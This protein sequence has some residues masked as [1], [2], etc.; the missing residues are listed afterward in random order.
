[1]KRPKRRDWQIEKY[2]II[3]YDK[4]NNKTISGVMDLKKLLLSIVLLIFLTPINAFAAINPDIFDYGYFGVT[5]EKTKSSILLAEFPYNRHQWETIEIDS[6][7]R[8]ILRLYDGKGKVV[9]Q[10]ILD[11]PQTLDLTTLQANGIQLQLSKTTG[12][13]AR[14]KQGTTTNPLNKTVI[15]TENDDEF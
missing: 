12:S 7:G 11:G 8:Y 14:L 4:K 15:F 5:A 13:F 9:L 2:W 10:N 1:M 6:D 3:F